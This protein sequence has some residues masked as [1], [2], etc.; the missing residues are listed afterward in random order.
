MLFKN[1][2]KFKNK[3][4]FAQRG[5]G[6]S[7]YIIIVA[8]IAVGAIGVFSAFGGVIRH[9]VAGMANELAGNDG[10]TEVTAAGTSAAAATTSAARV[11]T[12]GDYASGNK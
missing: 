7:E 8:L 12:M 4:A 2:P 10:T 6:M 5:Q 3:R 11:K 1:C 9:Q